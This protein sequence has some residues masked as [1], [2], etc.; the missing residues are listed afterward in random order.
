MTHF[1][2]EFKELYEKIKTERDELKLQSH[3]AKAELKDKWNEAEENWNKF[4]T[5]FMVIEKSTVTAAKDVGEGFKALGKELKHAYQDIRT[6][7]KS[8]KLT[9]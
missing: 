4:E 6:G 3:L 8:S 5:K 2:D 7:I 9:K 1:K